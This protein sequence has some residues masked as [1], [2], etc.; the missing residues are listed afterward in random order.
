MASPTQTLR[1]VVAYELKLAWPL[2]AFFLVFFLAPLML[3]F[4]ISLYTD[5]T[6]TH[7]GLAQYAKFLLDPFSLKVLGSTLWL[8]VPVTALCLLLG[9]PLAWLYVRVPSSLEGAL[10]RIVLQ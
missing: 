4:F 6:M 8:G 2:G 7:F 5:T 3:L 9:F 10:M 1:T